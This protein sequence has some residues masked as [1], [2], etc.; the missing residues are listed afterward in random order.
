MKKN[1]SLD[2][3]VSDHTLEVSILIPCLNEAETINTCIVKAHKSLRD[4]NIAGE[5]IVADNGSTDGSQNIAM[6][7]GARLI[8]V[9][10]K[11]YGNALS[12]G[13]KAANGEYV[14]MGDAD[15]SYDFLNIMPFIIKLRA[16]FD[17]VMGNRFTGGISNGAMPFLHRYLGNPVLS[18]IGRLFFNSPVGDFYCGLRGFKR[19]S[20]LKLGLLTTGMEFAIEMVVKSTMYGLKITEV[21]TTLSP[22]GR[23]SHAPHLR[24]WHDGW[25]TLRFLLLYSPKWLFLLPGIFMIIAGLFI[26]IWLMPKARTLGTLTFDVHT[27]LYAAVMISVGFQTL[28]FSAFTKIYASREGLIPQNDVLANMLNYYKLEHG[29]IAGTLLCIIGVVGSVVAFGDWEQRAFGNLNPFEMMRIV[30]PS[31]LCILLGFQTIFSSFFLSVLGLADK[32]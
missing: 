31:A 18:A 5:V 11:G 20:I 6:N 8:H 1:T 16:G 9:D 27:L 4:Y 21:P 14:I 13:I 17:L 26:G 32:K 28:F 25:R 15:D 2:K 24:T 22:D 30:I 23:M 3:I 29:L 10:Q 12:T 19:S 7:A